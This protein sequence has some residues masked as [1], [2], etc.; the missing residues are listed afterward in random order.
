[1]ASYK[2]VN[3]LQET[4]EICDM[5]HRKSLDII[6]PDVG[7]TKSENYPEVVT[8]EDGLEK[9]D[10]KLSAD[11]DPYYCFKLLKQLALVFVWICLVSLL[12]HKSYSF[13]CSSMYNCWVTVIL[14]QMGR[15]G[16]SNQCLFASS[17]LA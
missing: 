2:P 6:N 12:V 1:M 9:D 4:S 5:K 8:S 7:E 14:F 11:T 13:K 17:P 15:R 10:V 16:I 3:L